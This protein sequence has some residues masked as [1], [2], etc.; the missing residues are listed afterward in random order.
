MIFNCV[1]NLIILKKKWKGKQ[2]SSEATKYLS[3]AS[4]KLNG[5]NK[6]ELL[7][8]QTQGNRNCEYSKLLF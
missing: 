3:T 2:S 8:T 6:V 1:H 5:R 4:E 7:R